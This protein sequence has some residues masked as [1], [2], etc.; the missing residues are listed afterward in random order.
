MAD[1]IETAEVAF[2]G[3]SRPGMAYLEWGAIFG[4][5]AVA[6][7]I[8]VVLMNF[9]AAVGLNVGNPLLADGSASW[10]VLVAGLWVIV[11]SISAA[12][13]GGYLSGRMRS[14]RDDALES[15]VEVRDGTHGLVVWAGSTLIVA[16]IA[17][18]SA[19]AG[20]FVAAVDTNGFEVTE[21]TVRFTKN[22]SIIFAFA[23]AAG[24]ALAAAAA[25]FSGISGGTHR[26]G[27]LSVHDVV[28][29]MLRKRS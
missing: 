10:N 14:R 13:A 11:V 16:A 9:G 25:W 24:P 19:L 20:A 23:T 7:A 17:G 29:V 28:P 22:S 12:S 1:E 27:G 26:D 5:I 3:T 18:V 2:T 21:Q 8:S 6:C 4:G 15:E